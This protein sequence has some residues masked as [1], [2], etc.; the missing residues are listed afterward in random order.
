MCPVHKKTA[1]V[2]DIYVI[3]YVSLALFGRYQN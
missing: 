1:G 2:L 3:L